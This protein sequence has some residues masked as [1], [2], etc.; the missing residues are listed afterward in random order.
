[1]NL[2]RRMQLFAYNWNLLLTIGLLRLHLFVFRDL[3][4]EPFCLQ[5]VFARACVLTIEGFWLEKGDGVQAVPWT[6]KG[7]NCRQDNF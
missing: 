4:W 5:F 7:F 2:Q 6:A 3:W 1:M